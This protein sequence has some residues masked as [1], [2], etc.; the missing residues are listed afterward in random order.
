MSQPAAADPALRRQQWII[1]ACL[2]LIVALAW[3]WLLT[4]GSWVIVDAKGGGMATMPMGAGMAGMPGIAPSRP[5][6][7]WAYLIS[8][9]AM[10]LVM[11]T[12]MMLP[13]ATPMVLLYARFARGVKA[14]GGVLLPTF[15]FAGVYL[16]TRAANSEKP[17]QVSR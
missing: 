12:A 6:A 4:P 16:L 15:A 5:A 13:S 14:Q 7:G 2:A 1:G 9:F 3:A 8:A 10:W 11:M 17:A